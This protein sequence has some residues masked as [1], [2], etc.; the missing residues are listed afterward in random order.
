MAGGLRALIVVL[1]RG[2]LRI[3]E[4]SRSPNAT[5]TQGAGRYWCPAARAADAA[6][7]VWTPGAGNS[8]SRGWPRIELPVGPLFCIIDGPT[9]GRPWSD[10]GVRVEFRRLAVHA[11]VRRRFAPHQLR[12]A[13]AVELAREG[14]PLNI[15]QRQLRHANLGTTSIYLQGIDTEEIIAAVHSP[16]APMMSATAGPRL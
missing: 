2:G 14:V 1:G 11:G 5:S 7:S 9:R 13:H 4:R 3:Q 15:I 6:R 10:S 12:H 16:R 8:R